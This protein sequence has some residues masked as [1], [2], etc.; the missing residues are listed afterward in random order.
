MQRPRSSV[1]DQ[2]SGAIRDALLL[3]YLEQT[4]CTIHFI[5]SKSLQRNFLSQIFPCKSGDQ[6]MRETSLLHHKAVWLLK[7]KRIVAEEQHVNHHEAVTRKLCQESI[8]LSAS[9]TT[10]LFVLCL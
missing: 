4:L 5:W 2:H 3:R 6:V 1:H 8:C 7:L 10:E 9:L